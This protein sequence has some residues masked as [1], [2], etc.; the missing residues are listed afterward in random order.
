MGMNRP[1]KKRINLVVVALFI[2]VCFLSI[3]FSAYN[4]SMNITNAMATVTPDAKIQV[5]GASFDTS[6]NGGVNNMFDYTDNTLTGSIDL[7]NSN[8]TVTY[9]VVITNLGNVEVGLASITNLD[10]R[11]TYEITGYQ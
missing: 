8:S 4:D 1:R 2:A 5:T 10:P 6:T 9:E 11:L 3:G 7:P